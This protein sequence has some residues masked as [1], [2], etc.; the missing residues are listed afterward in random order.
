MTIH[1]RDFLAGGAG[2]MMLASSANLMPAARAAAPE[3]LTL[4]PVC[5]LLFDLIPPVRI[6]GGPRGSRT[7][8]RV[9]GGRVEG[10]R[11]NGKILEGGGDWAVM[12]AD[13]IFEVDIRAAIETDDGATIY[14]QY[15]GLVRMSPENWKRF[16][17][18]EK[19]SDTDYYFRVTPRFETGDERYAWLNRSVFVG[20]GYDLP[21][22]T[23]YRIFEVL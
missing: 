20:A 17:G 23:K 14:T 9:A 11:L 3:G 7:I 4:A 21:P 16:L 6:P 10:P 2:A 1:R 18:G 8:L 12:R 13:G 19:P 15:G 22:T 5:D